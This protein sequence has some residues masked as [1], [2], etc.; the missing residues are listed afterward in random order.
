MVAFKKIIF[1]NKPIALYSDQD[2]TL[3]SHEF[4]SRLKENN[5]I[6]NINTLNDHRSLSVI[7][8][9]TKKSKL[10]LTTHMLENNTNNWVDQL[11]IF[12]RNYNSMGHSA[13]NDIPPNKVYIPENNSNVFNFHSKK[14]RRTFYHRTW[15]LVIW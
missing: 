2:A 9:F 14:K 11:P 13:I 12:L 3:T 6:Y 1:G 15:I 4:S 10:A 8:V 7:D 5:I